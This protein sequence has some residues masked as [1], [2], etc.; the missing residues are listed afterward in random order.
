MKIQVVRI[1]SKIKIN[2]EKFEIINKAKYLIIL[3]TF[4]NY[5]NKINWLNKNQHTQCFLSTSSSASHFRVRKGYFWLIISPSK[6][7]VN[8]GYSSVN[9]FI[10]R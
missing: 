7:V 1:L 2:Y 9:P 5:D 10:C 4:M 8:F 6:N 3:I